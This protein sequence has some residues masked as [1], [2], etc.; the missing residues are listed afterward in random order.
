MP[1]GTW[2][3]TDSNRA[4]STSIRCGSTAEAANWAKLRPG[5]DPRVERSG[6]FGSVPDSDSVSVDVSDSAS[7][8][9]AD[10]VSVLAWGAGAEARS[11]GSDSAGSQA[12]STAPAEES[13]ADASKALFERSKAA[14]MYGPGNRELA[15]RTP[16]R[17][18]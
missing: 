17:K 12:D 2:S 8:A 9:A 13:P 16:S 15:A 11:S 3:K 10:P 5:S 1:T 14:G 6:A 7:N 4:R 18:V